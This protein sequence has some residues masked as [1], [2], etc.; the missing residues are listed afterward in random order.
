MALIKCEECGKEISNAAERCPNCGYKT[1]RGNAVTGAKLLLINLF[2]VVVL[3]IVGAILIFNSTETL[4]DHSSYY[5][6]YE[7]WKED[8]DTLWEIAKLAL[9]IGF[10]IGGLFDLFK[11]KKSADRLQEYEVSKPSIILPKNSPPAFI[12]EEKRKNGVCEICKRT[13]MV[14]SC[15]IPHQFGEQ[16]LCPICIHRYNATIND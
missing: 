7:L 13:G 14:A 16:D 9:G 4:S 11:L 3:M 5:W 2:I 8:D 10:I 15:K 6:E 12:P 1:S